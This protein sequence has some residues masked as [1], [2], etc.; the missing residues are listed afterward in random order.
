MKLTL[1][2]LDILFRILKRERRKKK[3]IR[4]GIPGR[5]LH[6][7]NVIIVPKQIIKNEDTTGF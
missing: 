2:L 4:S 7:N 6:G 5:D 3:I 1:Q